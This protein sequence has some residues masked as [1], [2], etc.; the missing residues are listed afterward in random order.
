MSINF[1]WS[2][3]SQNDSFTYR[4]LFPILQILRRVWTVLW[5]PSGSQLR[6]QRPLWVI[7]VIKD[8]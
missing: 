4:I 7:L 2:T 6:M 8:L 5:G 3:T 1:N